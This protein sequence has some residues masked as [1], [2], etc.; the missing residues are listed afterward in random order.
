[1]FLPEREKKMK[2]QNALVYMEDGTFQKRDFSFMGDRIIKGEDGREVFDADGLYL[3]PGLIDIHIHGCAG[4]D[5][6]DGTQA[7]IDGMAAYLARRGITAFTPAMM[8]LPEKEMLRIAETA[9]T[10]QTSRFAEFCGIHMEGPFLSSAKNGAQKKTYLRK[11]N[12]EFYQKMQRA[13]NQKIKIVDIAPELDG[14]MEWISAVSKETVV[15]IA[16]TNADYTTVCQAF[17]KGARHV[18]HLWNAMPPFLHR[19]PGVIG[20]ALEKQCMVEL[21]CDGLHVHPSVVRA[22]FQMFGAERIVLI[23]DSMMAAGLT[24]GIYQ[25]GGQKVWV[26]NSRA[27]L[28]DGT[29]AG[30]VTDLMECMRCAVGFGIPFEQVV[31]TVTMNPAKVI[32]VDKEMGSL[33]VGKLANFVLLDAD[34]QVKHVFIRG[35][36]V[37]IGK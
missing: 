15:S 17:L 36:E 32:G 9:A 22:T 34:L 28:A 7:S 23:S 12:L 6:C 30:A 25:L 14:A 33:E 26:K 4:Q 19:A 31:Q 3:L 24:D 29:I 27:L 10:Y 35:K 2:I 16:H 5:F 13:S 1:M 8:A 18:T 11:P 20:A 21:I 37:A